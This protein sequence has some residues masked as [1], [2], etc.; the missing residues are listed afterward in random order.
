MID[1]LINKLFFRYTKTSAL[2]CNC[3]FNIRLAPSCPLFG[4]LAVMRCKVTSMSDEV[5]R[6]QIVPLVSGDGPSVHFACNLTQK[7]AIQT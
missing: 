2:F 1:L 7:E 4:S 6:G 5:T 3:Q